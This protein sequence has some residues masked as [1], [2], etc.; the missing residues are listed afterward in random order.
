MTLMTLMTP[1]TPS[2]LHAGRGV[3]YETDI[4]SVC[5]NSPGRTRIEAPA[6]A[7]ATSI[8]PADRCR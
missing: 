6:T 1:M 2:Q 7:A 5:E 3:L 4:G 8:S